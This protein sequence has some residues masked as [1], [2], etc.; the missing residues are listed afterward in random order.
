ME[1]YPDRTILYSGTD[2]LTG[3]AFEVGLEISLFAE[4]P[5]CV[6]LTMAL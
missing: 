2:I 6:E 3:V 4:R 5:D 1:K